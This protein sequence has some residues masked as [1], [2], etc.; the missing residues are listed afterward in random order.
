VEGVVLLVFPR[1]LA[2]L[3]QD[4]LHEADLPQRPADDKNHRGGV[5]EEAVLGVQV[6][7]LVLCEC[8]F[9][10]RGE[11]DRHHTAEQ[12]G[13]SGDH[14]SH[15]DLLAKHERRE[16]NVGNQRQ[17]AQWSHDGLGCGE[18]GEGGGEGVSV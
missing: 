4:V 13:E 9:V 11:R 2:K 6:K 14:V 12:N 5:P 10:V 15:L 7:Q 17:S 8:D 18:S 3:F 16:E 1:V